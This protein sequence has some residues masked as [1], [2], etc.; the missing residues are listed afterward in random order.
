MS[1]KLADFLCTYR[2]VPHTSTGCTPAELLFGRAPRTHLS[3]VLPNVSERVK[4]T[5]QPLE[6]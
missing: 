1:T 4:K 5:L 2:N 6:V 3:M